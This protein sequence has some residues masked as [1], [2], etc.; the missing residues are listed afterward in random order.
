MTPDQPLNFHV[1]PGGAFN[2]T[3]SVPGDKSISHRS[4]MFSMIAEGVSTVRGLLYSEDVKATLACCR[5]L[6]TQIEERTVTGAS[7]HPDAVSPE[8][9]IHGLGAGLATQALTQVDLGNSGTAMR[10]LAGLFCGYPVHLELVGDESLNGRP[11]GRIAD[12]LKRMGA[13]VSTS[14][15]GTPPVLI[16]P[17]DHL[18]GIE[19]EMKVA[20]A[21][22]KSAIL[23]ATL[24]ATGQTVIYE[25]RVSRDHTERMLRS[26]GVEVDTHSDGASSSASRQVRMRGGQTLKATDIVVPGD[27]SSAAFFIV[28]AAIAPDAQVTIKG[29]GI[30]PTR[31][32]VVTVLKQMGAQIECVERPGAGDEPMADL[33]IRSSSLKGIDIGAD[34][35]ALAIDEIPIIAVAA[36]CATGR[37]TITGAEELRV[38]ES[39]RIAGVVQGL[40]AIGVV[41]EELPD[42]M[43]IEGGQIAG[44]QVDSLGDH[45]LAMAF[46]IAALRSKDAIKVNNINNIATSF[47]NFSELVSVLGMRLDTLTDSAS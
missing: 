34:L 36:A 21:Q 33:T 43:T 5:L 31:D 27:L 45:R 25:P 17:V 6:G 12:P 3:I 1:Q 47:P 28:G 7:S 15:D 19:H 22:I 29:V 42:G 11:M 38:K 41:V 40:K 8:I 13:D 44:G 16:R 39:D 20:S 32:G 26:Y 4:V 35:V 9:V 18:T 2:G 30:N 10:L 37:T 24:R 46:T 14:E 23:L